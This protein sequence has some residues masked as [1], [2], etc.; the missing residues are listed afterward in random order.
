MTEN[1]KL[2]NSKFSIFPSDY[3]SD[4]HNERKT[5]SQELVVQVLY[6]YSF[7]STTLHQSDYLNNQKKM[8]ATIKSE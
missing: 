5:L 2:S 1:I 3:T 4:L 8:V 6:S 7:I